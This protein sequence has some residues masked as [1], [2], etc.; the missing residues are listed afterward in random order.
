MSAGLYIFGFGGHARSVAD[1]ALSAGI[2]QLL[3]I[4]PKARV[5]EMFAGFPAVTQLPQPVDSNWHAF[6]ASGDNALRRKICAGMT[7][8][9]LALIARTASIGVEAVVEEGVFVGE[10]AHVG[11][12]ARIGKGAIINSG[13]IVEHETF[14]GAFTHI[15]VNA[16]VAGRC[17]IGTETLIGA[18]ATVLDRIRICDRAIV[19]AGATV[20]SDLA[21]P[22]VYVGTP[23]RL[24]KGA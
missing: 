18:G 7:I 17:H 6:P 1:V 14:I 20:V 2:K 13:A 12:G 21:E 5:G 4:D 19:G 9:L 15:S 8:P 23:A 3:F 11:A 16:T 22:G 10:H 24:I